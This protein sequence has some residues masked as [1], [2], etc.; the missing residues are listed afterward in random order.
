MKN[1]L[2]LSRLLNFFELTMT[3]RTLLKRMERRKNNRTPH[4][5]FN[6]GQRIC[7][8]GPVLLGVTIWLGMAKSTGRRAFQLQGGFSLAALG[9]L[10][11]TSELSR[12]DDPMDMHAP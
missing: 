11:S 2:L 6:F 8:P 10:M 12:S 9:S 4:C 3:D 7:R 5:S 1:L